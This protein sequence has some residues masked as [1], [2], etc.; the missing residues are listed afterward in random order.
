MGCEETGSTH[1]RQQSPCKIL[2]IEE[3]TAQ[4]VEL[5]RSGSPIQLRHGSCTW[6]RKPAAD[7]LS[8][9][10]INSQD[11]TYLEL[12]DEIPVFKVENDLASKTSKQDDGEEEYIHDDA[13]VPNAATSPNPTMQA[14]LEM[15]PHLSHEDEKQYRR[16]IDDIRSQVQQFVTPFDP[17]LLF[18]RF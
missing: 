18:T 10:D 7:Y 15:F 3:D 9:I 1:D 16:R 14:F 13:K 8:R 12:H 2:P 11:R 17:T 4:A 6:N 5:L